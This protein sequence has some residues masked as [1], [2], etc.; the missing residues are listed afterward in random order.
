MDSQIDKHPYP[1]DPKRRCQ[2]FGRAVEILELV[3]GDDQALE[4][5]EKI[6]QYYKANAKSRGDFAV[7]VTGTQ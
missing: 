4:M 1:I 5:L 3:T 7:M 6:L 2:P